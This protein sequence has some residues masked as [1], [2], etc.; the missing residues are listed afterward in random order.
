MGKGRTGIET[1]CAFLDLPPPVVDK[2]YSDHN[3]D[4]CKI[5]GGYAGN[6]QL[7]AVSRL[8]EAC[9]AGSGDVLDVTVTFDGTWSKRGFTAPYG[10]CYVLGHW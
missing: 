9:G 4:I 3:K 10:V 2:A 6:E 5:L 1:I 8:R 7:A